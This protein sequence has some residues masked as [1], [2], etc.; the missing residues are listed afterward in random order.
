MDYISVQAASLKWGVCERQV[1]KLCQNNRLSGA[2][3][4][5]RSWLIPSSLEKPN[6]LRHATSIIEQRSNEE[7]IEK[8]EASNNHKEEIILALS[9]EYY[10]TFFVNF[11][12][13]NYEILNLNEDLMILKVSEIV[14]KNPSYRVSFRSFI[15]K[16]VRIE[17]RVMFNR[18][19]TNGG[20][21]EMFKTDTAQSF[22]FRSINQRIP[23]LAHVIKV[24][25]GE[26]EDEKFI[27]GFKHLEKEYIDSMVNLADLYYK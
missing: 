7:V 22:F 5:G 27:I 9:R 6:D 19:L 21:S 14:G 25:G 16:H 3:K 17:D 23:F 12:K 1:Q 2:K 15:D 20:V 26:D 8:I 4:I 24:D 11:T 13:D 10:A 18:L